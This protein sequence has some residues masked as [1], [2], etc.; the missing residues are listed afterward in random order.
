MS[1]I[2]VNGQILNA[3]EYF[4][5]VDHRGLKYGDGIFES[6]RMLNGRMPLLP[7]HMRRLYRGL[8][9]LKINKPKHFTTAFF[10]KEIQRITHSKKNTRIRITVFRSPGGLY[11][12]TNNQ[13]HYLIEYQPIKS[14]GW[15]WSK[16]GLNIKICPAVQLPITAWSGIKTTNSLPY[17]LAGLW[18]QEHRID[19]CILLN[20]QGFV[21]EASSSN[22]FYCKENRLFTP[23]NQS[24]A[25]QGVMRGKVLKIVK[26]NGISFKMK[27][28]LPAELLSADEVFLTNAIQGIRWVKKMEGA[29]FRNKMTRKI[30]QH[31]N[32]NSHGKK[33]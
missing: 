18:K 1:E 26:E 14:N 25:I 3:E 19:D 6:I 13:P 27:N 20:Q 28:I 16:K 9:V 31:L 22:V 30:W 8:Q 21:S 29:S 24:G 33:S 5:D 10:R 4:A 17:I 2:N 32:S 15:E 7:D 12:P 11:T 23:T